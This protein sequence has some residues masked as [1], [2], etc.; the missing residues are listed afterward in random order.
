MVGGTLGRILKI[1]PMVV[2]F[3]LIGS[4]VEAIFILPGHLAHFAGRDAAGGRTAKLAIRLKNI[5][6]PIVTRSVRWRWLVVIATLFGFVGTVLLATKMPFQFAAPGKPTE[7]SIIYKL[8][9]GVGRDATR[10]QG[11]GI[12]AL[13]FEDF[14]V[15][16]EQ[17]DGPVRTSKLRV[18]S[19]RDPRTQ[20]LETGTNVGIIRFEFNLHDEV[21]EGYPAMVAHLKDA[22][23]EN[24]DLV[25]N[26]VLEPQA[27]PP[28][29]AA[30]T[31]RVRGR[32]PEQID[33]AV[34]ELKTWLRTVEGVRDV[35]DDSGIGKETFSV[36]VDPDLAALYGLNQLEVANAVRSAIDGIV[37]TE[38]SI[39]EQRVEII[40]RTR[41][42]QT[43]D[44]SGIASLTVTNAAGGVVRLDQV[45]Q[46]ERTREIGSIR[47][48][49][50]QRT[51]AVT[52]D[53]ESEII[54]ALGATG[55]IQAHWDEHIAP[56]YP[57]LEIQFGGEAEEINESLNDLPGAFLLALGMIYIALALQFRS[58]VQ[59]L[60]IMCAVPFGIMG[61]VLGL[62]GMGYE[63]SLFAL[64][65][66]VA[67]AGIVVNDSLVMVDF[68]NSR[69]RDGLE[70]MDAAVDGA[71]Q[72]LRPIL[73]TTLT[74][75]FGLGPLALGLGGK[76]EIL[77]PMAVALAA[78]LGVSTSLVLVVVP[79]IY[80]I[81]E[82]DI[83]GV[84]YRLFPGRRPQV[85]PADDEPASE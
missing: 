32:Y 34:R 35:D 25:A 81:I 48:R 14:G 74:T 56:R 73:S 80:V 16:E 71:L 55:E 61:A 31:A 83:L 12:R 6:R 29:G 72:R 59:P 9:A 47:R 63:L 41:G 4:L 62:F 27:G 68:I 17:E 15:S 50:N 76:D 60:I 51:V 49:D 26:S 2:I 13:V 84:W 53:V 52:A 43:L 22:L 45:A 30:I 46:L 64:F 24:P 85:I 54:T 40:V 20:V 11:E 66:I 82:R 65:G 75:V 19:T 36:R 7:L 58:Y 39:D 70:V 69:R 1:M 67:L 37:A 21:I 57:E 33:A 18:G 23:A 38:V 28:A 8:P 78:G 5:Y 44:R 42:G 77:A 3:C 79:P 10:A